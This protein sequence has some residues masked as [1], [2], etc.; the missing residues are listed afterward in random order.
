G[1]EKELKV[2]VDDKI[3]HNPCIF[4]SLP[5][6]FALLDNHK[7]VEEYRDQKVFSYKK[8]LLLKSTA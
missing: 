7:Q 5:Y 4:Y 8:L 2:K 1:Y 3:E 6:A